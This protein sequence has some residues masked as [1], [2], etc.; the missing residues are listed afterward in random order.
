MGTHG[1]LLE[2]MGAYGNF[3]RENSWELMRSLC[4]KN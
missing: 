3:V 2:L 1:N 4:L